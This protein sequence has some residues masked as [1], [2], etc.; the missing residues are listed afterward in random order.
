MRYANDFTD[1]F[2]SEV[3][4]NLGLKDRVAI[5]TGASRGLGRAT[6]EALANEGAKIVAVA[7]GKEDL[8]ALQAQHPDRCAV[9]VGDLLEP[10]VP[11]RAVDAALSAFGRLDIA[12]VNTPGPRSITPLEAQESDF[13]EAFARVFY[14]AVRLVQAA[15]GPMCD[16]AWGRIF[17]VSSTSV[18]APKPFLSLSAASRSALWA[19]AKSAAPAL[20]EHNVTINALFAGP[21][22]TD[23]A[24]ELGVKKDRPIGSPE[25]F[26]RLVAALCGESCRFITGTGYLIDG[27][28]LTGI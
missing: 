8:E 21:H 1:I 16:R 28:E 25:D 24:R 18:K 12:I 20:F 7:R 15:Q 14:P 6:A 26:G 13:E 5:V 2:C 3:I 9:V 27:G 19:W 11:Q 23:R 22:D 10:D 4:M 17:I